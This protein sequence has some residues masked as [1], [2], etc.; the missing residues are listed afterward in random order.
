MPCGCSC[1]LRASPLP[2]VSSLHVFGPHPE[3][4]QGQE[5][6]FDARSPAGHS[7]SLGWLVEQGEAGV[8]CIRAV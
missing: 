7:G 5:R 3:L 2:C 1:L 6:W 8:L 4:R